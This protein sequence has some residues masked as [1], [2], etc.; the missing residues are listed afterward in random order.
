MWYLRPLACLYD[1]LQPTVGHLNGFEMA[2]LDGLSDDDGELG[3]EWEDEARELERES[4]GDELNAEAFLDGLDE[5]EP[6]TGDDIRDPVGVTLG[7][8]CVEGENNKAGGIHL[9]FGPFPFKAAS[10]TSAENWEK[11]V[12]LLM[13]AFSPF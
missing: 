9:L 13:K 10:G 2:W 4:A 6:G 3:V 11:D 12:K 1:L 8:F 5:V 7:V